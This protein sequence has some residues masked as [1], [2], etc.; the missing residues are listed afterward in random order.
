MPKIKYSEDAE[1]NINVAFKE[2]L[3]Q[4]NV[5][6]YIYNRHSRTLEF[7]LGFI[8]LFMSLI[9]TQKEFLITNLTIYPFYIFWVGMIAIVISAIFSFYAYAQRKFEVGP[10]IK[11]FL[12]EC[13]S[14][15]RYNFKLK[16]F[17]LINKVNKDNHKTI[18]NRSSHMK[19]SYISLC[20]G[21]ILI[22]IAKT[23]M[24]FIGA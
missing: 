23:C 16:L 20:I 5:Q 12:N 19:I 10:N 1:I 3:R 11:D 17:S 9:V 22:A 14:E 6:D 2:A 18:S 21:I 7:I 4:F 8:A 24:L 15:T 13:L